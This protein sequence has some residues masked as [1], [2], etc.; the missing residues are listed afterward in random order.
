MLRVEL[1]QLAL[2]EAAGAAP[3]GREGAHEVL[4]A[5][6]RAVHVGLHRR[7]R[8]DLVRLQ[9]DRG[10]RQRGIAEAAGAGHVEA[11]LGV[12][13]GQAGHAQPL[14]G[15]AGDVPA[16]EGRVVEVGRIDHGGH[17]HGGELL[18]DLLVGEAVELRVGH[19][20]AVV[21][22]VGREPGGALARRLGAALDDGDPLGP[23]VPHEV[24]DDALHHPQVGDL[25]RMLEAPGVVGGLGIAPVGDV[26]HLDQHLV[27][28][29]D[30]L[31]DRAARPVQVQ[32]AADHGVHLL[33]GQIR[34][35]GGGLGQL[36]V[37]GGGDGHRGTALAQGDGAGPDDGQALDPDRLVL[38]EGGAGRPDEP[39][40]G[41]MDM[42][43]PSRQG[44]HQQDGRG[45]GPLLPS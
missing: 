17:L 42:D 11:L 24:G 3:P 19:R 16:A 29:P 18:Q 7:H 25:P 12:G 26:V 8:D 4:D 36:R 35:E 5:Q 2:G 32:G 41:A 45:E 6:G 14:E 20:P 30:D 43:V 40:G 1:E 44:R 23:H 15:A 22:G 39:D 38:A 9:E 10:H 37:D 28:G 21:G 31:A 33:V 13:V 34:V 27:A